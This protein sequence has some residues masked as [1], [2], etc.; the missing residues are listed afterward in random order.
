MEDKLLAKMEKYIFS[1]YILD[2]FIFAFAFVASPTDSCLAEARTRYN[3]YL[4]P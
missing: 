4:V 3:F 2:N 1:K